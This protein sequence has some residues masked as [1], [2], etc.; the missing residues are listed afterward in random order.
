MQRCLSAAQCRD[1]SQQSNYLPIPL[2]TLAGQD[3]A[4]L[5]VKAAMA[6]EAMEKELQ[7]LK[8]SWR[9]PRTGDQ[10]VR[11]T[12]QQTKP[13]V[14]EET[15]EEGTEGITMANGSEA[16]DFGLPPATTDKTL[17]T[18]DPHTPIASVIYEIL[19]KVMKVMGQAT[20]AVHWGSPKTYPYP[21]NSENMAA[22]GYEDL[23]NTVYLGLRVYTKRQAPAV[24]NGQLRHEM[25]TSF[26]GLVINDV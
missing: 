24:V 16:M 19:R 18:A 21:R 15:S 10:A 9:T 4:E 2:S 1:F 13:T 6:T 26:A 7:A 3:L 11:S 22:N 8:V 5:E 12:D 25:A 14:E 23:Q 17:S 20:R